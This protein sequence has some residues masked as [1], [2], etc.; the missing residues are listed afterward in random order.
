MA[1]WCC[2]LVG[3]TVHPHQASDL[4]YRQ[5]VPCPSRTAHGRNPLEFK[6]R[7]LWHPCPTRMT[8]PTALTG[9]QAVG[10]VR[11]SRGYTDTTW[12]WSITTPWV[13]HALVPSHASMPNRSCHLIPCGRSTPLFHG[14]FAALTRPKFDFILQALP[15]PSVPVL[16]LGPLRL[17]NLP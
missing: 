3:S 16:S 11:S 17:K 12:S 9:I 5:S 10:A 15:M 6:I 8:Q 14:G 13:P 4:R 7:P 1:K 2:N